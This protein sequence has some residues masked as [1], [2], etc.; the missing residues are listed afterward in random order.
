MENTAKNIAEYIRFLDAGY[1][2]VTEI[3]ED[4]NETVEV[5]KPAPWS[6]DVYSI[7]KFVTTFA[8]GLAYDDGLI[9]LNK[10]ITSLI[11]NCPEPREKKWLSV[12]L[13]DCL[14]HKTGMLSGNLDIDNPAYEGI[15]DW[16]EYALALPIE[17]KTGENYHYTDAAF[18]LAV[19]AV[20]LAIGGDVMAYL[21]HRVFLPLGFREYSWSVCP[22]GF[23]VGGSGFCANDR[24]LARLASVWANGGY[25]KGK[26]ILSQRFINLAF[27]NY[28][29]LEERNEYPGF[30]YKTGAFGQVLIMLPLEKR[31]ICM[32]GFCASE[33]RTLIVD[34]FFTREET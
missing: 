12:T 13:H 34:R 16:L 15:E 24:D 9:D 29:G 26:K 10:P 30:Y 2:G 8:V 19:R 1:Y 31:A 20:E 14:R 22:G 6:T 21:R 18:Y 3:D 4:Y 11:K 5:I 25:Y 33:L 28:Y 32:R 27:E 17:G 23:P 7:S